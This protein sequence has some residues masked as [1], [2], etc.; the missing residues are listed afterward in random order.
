MI[1]DNINGYEN[2]VLVKTNN[3]I[4]N[5]TVIKKYINE[6]FMYLENADKE[7]SMHQG[8]NTDIY[9]RSYYPYIEG[10]SGFIASLL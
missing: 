2:K 6:Y 8:S 3:S 4:S 5:I 7:K 10:D 1:S 9:S